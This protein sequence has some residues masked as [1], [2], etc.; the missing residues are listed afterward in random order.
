MVWR[1]ER[2]CQGIA[3]AACLLTE[4]AGKWHACCDGMPGRGGGEKEAGIRRG[5]NSFWVTREPCLCNRFSYP[6]K[7]SG[8]DSLSLLHISAWSGWPLVTVANL[9]QLRSPPDETGF[10]CSPH[11]VARKAHTRSIHKQ[12]L[13]NCYGGQAETRRG[14]WDLTSHHSQTH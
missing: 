3:I 14:V 13:A 11:V 7:I 6:V 4:R 2:L 1:L 8:Q 12:T 10:L 9:R 5:T